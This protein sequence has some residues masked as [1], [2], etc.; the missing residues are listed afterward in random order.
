MDLFKTKE[1]ESCFPTLSWKERLTGFA[2][3]AIL[4]FAIELLSFGAFAGNKNIKNIYL[5]VF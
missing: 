4:G 3:C 5:K 1:E 2:F